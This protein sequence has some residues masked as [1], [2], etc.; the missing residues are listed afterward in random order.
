MSLLDDALSG[1]LIRIRD[2]E[3]L[4]FQG[5]VNSNMLTAKIDSDVRYGDIVR[6][7]YGEEF[8]V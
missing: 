2:G 3:E 1:K 6:D 4:E 7:E 8:V 5:S